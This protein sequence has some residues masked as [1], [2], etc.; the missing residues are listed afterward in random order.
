M[1]E[2]PLDKIRNLEAQIKSKYGEIAFI[3]GACNHQYK[4]SWPESPDC[5]HPKCELCGDEK[6]GW[7]CEESPSK[8]CDYFDPS[9]PPRYQMNYDCCRYCGD[10][11]E[12]K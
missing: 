5:S 12:R 4:P 9:R 11:E 2:N 10:P 8:S 7:W 1:R 6:S 3:R